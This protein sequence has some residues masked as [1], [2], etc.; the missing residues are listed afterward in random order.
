MTTFN[1]PNSTQTYTVPSGVNKIV[2]IGNGA[3][4]GDGGPGGDDAGG[5]GGTGGYVYGILSVSPGD[6]FTIELA[7]QGADGD[8]VSGGSGA[9][10]GASPFFNGGDGGGT[11]TDV[12][13]EGEGGG[14]G[15]ATV[16]IR[17]SDSAQ[18][19]IAEGG[20]G[21]GGAGSDI[22]RGGGGGGGA[23][24]GSGA[25][26]GFESGDDGGGTGGGGDGGDGSFNADGGAG[27]DG[28]QTAHADLTET[29]TT[30]GGGN[31][32]SATVTLAPA[33]EWPTPGLT[34]QTDAQGVSLT[35]ND[36]DAED[37]YEVH[38]ST[39]SGFT[40][41]SGTLVTTRTADTTSY[42]DTGVTEGQ[43]TYYKV[44]AQNSVPSSVTSDEASAVSY[45][46]PNSNLSISNIG[47]D[48]AD[49]S[50][51]D[52]ASDETAHRVLLSRGR[53]YFDFDG[54]DDVVD[55]PG[56]AA[57]VAGTQ[58]VTLCARV[59]PE[60][61]GSSQRVIS[62]N[63]DYFL[64][65]QTYVDCGFTTQESGV[66]DAG[67]QPPLT[68]GV[69]QSIVAVIDLSKASDTVVVYVDG[70]EAATDTIASGETLD[71]NP[72]NVQVGS[73]E[74][75]GEFYQG[76]IA[77]A[78]VFGTALSAS[79]AADYDSGSLP[80]PSDL[81]GYWP[82]HENRSGTTPD[83]S[84]YDNDGT[85]SGATVQGTAY[86]DATGALAADTTSVTLTSLLNGEQYRA[87]VRVEG[88][89]GEAETF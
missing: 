52:N 31:T 53:R 59:A 23:R 62:R 78:C 48:S 28:G 8:E 79:Q 68:T 46:P 44:I 30:T 40:P 47:T 72:S 77:D 88:T 34:A 39:S 61:S 64:K 2:V 26:T 83:M 81:L 42:T 76:G 32:G 70:V 75:F 85:I 51:T 10:G 69:W 49:A 82:L 80:A 15:G 57:D 37:E 27:T 22:E 65:A 38:R 1:T 9:A 45:L 7:D 43:L 12:G 87:K 58:T 35:W 60:D 73:W 54:T 36:A 33:V 6:G 5:S 21:G 71:S 25:T 3:G 84:G 14:G 63:N 56:D 86:T 89:D 29:T 55:A 19:A 74:P 18:I 66:Y 67:A 13:S 50:W 17:D 16:V 41:D 24:G 4:G 11:G 20:G